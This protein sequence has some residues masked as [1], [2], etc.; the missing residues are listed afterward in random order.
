M[1]QD[2]FWGILLGLAAAFF[3]SLSYV[4]SRLFVTRPGQSAAGLFALSHVEMGIVALAALPFVASGGAPSASVYWRPL[5]GAVFFYL[6][7]Q[8]AMFA[9]LRWTEA[10]RISPLLGLKILVLALISCLCLRQTVAPLQWVAVALSVAAAFALNWSGGALPGRAALGVLVCCLGYSMSD[11]NIRW[12]VDALDSVGRLRATLLSCCMCYVATGALGAALLLRARG[13][14]GSAWLRAAPVA[15][16]WI[17][18][19]VFLFATFK[20][21]GVVFGNIVQSS[22]GLISIL[23]GAMIARWGFVALEQRHGASVLWR[24]AVAA[25]LMTA[26]VALYVL[27]QPA[28]R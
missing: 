13:L 8:G 10:S 15:V 9:T 26:A 14:S 17:L 4:F 18:A 2:V 1:S 16:A 5:A 28:G 27:G 21:I 12:L 20:L 6:V 22:R 19:M 25:A 23:M 11:L 3:Q 7:G 24:R